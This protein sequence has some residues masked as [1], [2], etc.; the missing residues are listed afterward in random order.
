MIGTPEYMSPEQV[1]GKD[2]DQR[3]D[4]YSLGII[5]YEMLTGRVPFV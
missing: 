5:L 2:A 4:I 1:D 3:S